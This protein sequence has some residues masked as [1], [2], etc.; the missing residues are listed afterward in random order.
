M[1]GLERVNLND[2]SGGG[3]NAEEEPITLDGATS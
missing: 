1:Y 3:I 2:I